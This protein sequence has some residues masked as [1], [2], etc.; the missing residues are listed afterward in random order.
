MTGQSLI[1]CVGAAK[2]GTSW[3]HEYLAGHPEC[4]LRKVKELHY[5]DALEA[6]GR[7]HRR[8][9]E[10]RLEAARTRLAGFSEAER[11]ANTYLPALIADLEDWLQVFDGMAPNDPGYLD[12]VGLGREK[13]AVVGDFTPAYATLTRATYRHM[14]GMADKVKF[15]FIMRDPLARLWSNI[16]MNAAGKGDMAIASEVDSYLAGNNR[17]LTLRSNYRRTLNRLLAVI[18]RE[19][20]HLEFYERLFTPE[21][22][23]RLC[24]F[25]GIAPKP[26]NFERVVHR[27]KTTGVEVLRVGE[28]RESLQPQY[29]YVEKLMGEVPQE[30]TDRMVIA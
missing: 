15:L 17:N 8:Q 22:I 21:A 6:K 20:L 4:F 18:P 7:W 24:A 10:A 2:S 11:A 30:W 29:N 12:Y 27:G 19:N 14:A 13:A 28:L 23:E 3:L 26:A 25:L 16:R 9:T 1:F 5:F